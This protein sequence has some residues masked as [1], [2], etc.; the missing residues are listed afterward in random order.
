MLRAA[1]IAEAIVPKAKIIN[2]LQIPGGNGSQQVLLQVRIAEVNKQAVT[3]LGVNLLH[4]RRRD[5]A[6]SSGGP[7]RSSSRPRP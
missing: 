7:R 3:E 1:E 4:R 5:P 6:E 2:M